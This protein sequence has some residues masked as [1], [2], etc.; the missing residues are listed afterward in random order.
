[1]LAEMMA[2]HKMYADQGYV[3]ANQVFSAR[4]MD[5]LR[6]S[7]QSI[8]AKSGNVSPSNGHSDRL[9]TLDDLILKREKADHSLVYK[10]SQSLGSS[11][12]T[13][14][15]LGGSDI[16]NLVAAATGF[17]VADL[18]LAP[19]YF[20]VQNPSDGRFDY[21]WHQDGAYYPWAKD[22]LTLWFPVNREVNRETGTI[23]LIPGS[24]HVQARENKTYVKHGFFRQIESEIET[25]E[26]SQER[27]VEVEP[28]DC[29]IMHG[30]LV[31]RSVAN[32]KRHT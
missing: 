7:F 27:F 28:G 15:L 16:L 26:A 17:D 20:I 25:R 24:H 11:A 22:M 1:M 5:V 9:D 18:H 6:K 8:L 29:C 32:R 19:L 4:S 10:A 30:D 13:Y 2:T 3:I 23:S 14:Q 21:P 12:A 31:H